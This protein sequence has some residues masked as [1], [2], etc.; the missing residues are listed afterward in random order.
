MSDETNKLNQQLIPV[1]EGEIGGVKQPVVDA[2]NLHAAV[3]SDQRFTDWMKSRI[4]EYGFVEGVDFLLHKIMKQKNG[5]RGGH[6]KTDYMLSL[7]MA[8]EIAMVERNEAGRQAR[9]Y[10]IEC[11]RRLTDTKSPDET[12]SQEDREISALYHLIRTRVLYWATKKLNMIYRPE[13]DHEIMF[14]VLSDIIDSSYIECTNDFY[15]KFQVAYSSE[16][17][18]EMKLFVK[19]WTPQFFRDNESKPK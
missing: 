6:N 14:S 12:E 5:Q 19:N 9:R 4:Q 3:G 16:H 18:S 15:K 11:E 17:Y 2:R 8:K 10:F 13:I 7:D 1:I